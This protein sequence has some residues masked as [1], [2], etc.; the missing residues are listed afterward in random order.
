MKKHY[1]LAVIG[2]GLAGLTLVRQ[3]LLRADKKV[4]LLDRS[5]QV[6]T[7]RQKLGES[8]VQVG[9]FYLSKMLDLEE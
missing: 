1:D 5:A 6:P 4:L 9:A 2:A 8:T 7:P 3:L